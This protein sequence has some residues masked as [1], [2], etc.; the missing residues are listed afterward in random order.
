MNVMECQGQQIVSEEKNWIFKS[1]LDLLN[2][3]LKVEH[4]CTSQNH[5]DHS[6]VDFLCLFNF[7]YP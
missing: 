6:F 4:P 5:R 3:C 2:P 7:Y 1:V